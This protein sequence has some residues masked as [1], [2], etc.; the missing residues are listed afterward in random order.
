MNTVKKLSGV[1]LAAAAATLFIAGCA[2]QGTG[3]A[4]TF[5]LIALSRH[6]QHVI[7][8]EQV[9]LVR[10]LGNVHVIQRGAAAGSTESS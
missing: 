2:T 9:V 10:S 5:N 6:D 1:A 4:S 8:V 3:S 7:A